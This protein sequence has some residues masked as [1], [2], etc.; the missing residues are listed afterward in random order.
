MRM[1]ETYRQ[2]SLHHEFV[3]LLRILRF[4]LQT[5]L[6]HNWTAV[7]TSRGRTTSRSDAASS[8]A[9]GAR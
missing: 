3:G 9:C 8:R 5:A 7:T 6:K 2:D 1:T 4:G